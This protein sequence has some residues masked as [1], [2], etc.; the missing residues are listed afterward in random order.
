[1]KAAPPKLKAQLKLHKIG[2][3]IHRVINNRTAPA[4]KLAKHLTKI[5]D[6]YITP[7]NRYAV[8]NS[9]NLANDLRNL[10]IHENHRLITFNVKDL[11]VNIPITE[12]LNI[13]K[14]KLLQNNGIQITHQIISLLKVVLTQNYFTFQQ[15][16][17][18]PE[19]GISM[20]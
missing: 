10:K 4:Y 17:Y 6:Q 11:Y 16:I 20:G 2:I 8:T 15:R 1:M 18:Q 13:V 19:Q 9:I 5:L 3:P 12:T 14:T 7:H